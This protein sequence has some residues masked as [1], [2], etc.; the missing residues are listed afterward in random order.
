MISRT[1]TT[2]AKRLP[3]MKAVS[4]ETFHSV[5]RGCGLPYVSAGYGRGPP[6]NVVHEDVHDRPIYVG[7]RRPPYPKVVQRVPLVLHTHCSQMDL[8]IQGH[9]H[10][11]QRQLPLVSALEDAREKEP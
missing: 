2:V 4:R 8:E 3:G 11:R 9:L 10:R 6:S 7:A 5:R 1:P